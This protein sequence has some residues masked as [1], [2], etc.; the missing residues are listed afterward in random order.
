ME[1]VRYRVATTT[2]KNKGSSYETPTAVVT[3]R[4]APS[5]GDYDNYHPGRRQRSRRRDGY[6]APDD[7]VRVSTLSPP[8]S[9]IADAVRRRVDSSNVN[10][11]SE[12]F[13]AQPTY[14]AVDSRTSAR[15]R[16]RPRPPFA[17][18]FGVQRG[19]MSGDYDY[20]RES[21]DSSRYHEQ[22]LREESHH[23]QRHRQR[24]QQQ[25]AAS[26]NPSVEFA[27]RSIVDSRSQVHHNPT[28]LLP[29]RAVTSPTPAPL[30]P[31]YLNDNKTL[32][33]EALISAAAAK[34]A[35]SS[36]ARSAVK[37][38][39]VIRNGPAK[40]SSDER[41]DAD[42]DV[43]TT[44]AKSSVNSY[45]VE[46][47]ATTE[48][49]EHTAAD[50][51]IAAAAAAATR[52]SRTQRRDATNSGV[53]TTASS[54]VS[55]TG[56]GISTG[57]RRTR[58]V[59]CDTAAGDQASQGGVLSVSGTKKQDN[60]GFE[61]TRPVNSGGSPPASA[62]T[63]PSSNG[64]H[65]G[66]S[67]RPAAL[68]STTGTTHVT[69]TKETRGT[70]SDNRKD[71][72]PL[73]TDASRRD[74]QRDDKTIK[75]NDVTELDR[76]T[77]P[78]ADAGTHHESPSS[79]SKVSFIKSI[80]SR[81]RSP[82]P[83]RYRRSR[84]KPQHASG[85]PSSVK[86]IGA[87]VAQRI[88][89]PVKGYLKQLRDRS[90]QR[91]RQTE[92]GNTSTSGEPKSSVQDRELVSDMD[93]QLRPSDA[94]AGLAANCDGR[95][96]DDVSSQRHRFGTDKK[97]QDDG[98]TALTSQWKS[99]SE[100]IT[101]MNRLDNLLKAN[102]LQHLRPSTTASAFQTNGPSVETSGTRAVSSTSMTSSPPLVSQTS[103]S[104]GC[105][106]SS[107]DR[108]L[109]LHQEPVERQ[110][111]TTMSRCYLEK[112][113]RAARRAVTVQLDRRTVDRQTPALSVTGRQSTSQAD[114]RN[115]Q[116]S[117]VPSLGEQP[118]DKVKDSNVDKQLSDLTTSG[119]TATGPTSPASEQ[120][121]T[122]NRSSSSKNELDL[123]E[124]FEQKKLE[125]QL[126]EKLALMEKERAGVIA[127]L[128]SQI[129]HRCERKTATQQR[130]AA[131]SDHL[132]NSSTT[133]GL[134]LPLSHNTTSP[135][136]S[137]NQVKT[138]A[139]NQKDMHT[140]EIQSH[141]DFGT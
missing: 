6:A 52:R 72:Q 135:A 140:I 81:T 57:T 122:D 70:A 92:A 69:N 117:V 115:P 22:R 77:S 132:Y 111:A 99:T 87:E 47:S 64:D 91:R 136:A 9:A 4:Q 44:T 34:L 65:V 127:K 93:S 38:L 37:P 2:R 100:L 13:W 108:S 98:T 83:S 16:S 28:T 66:D 75:D 96:A 85:S 26:L 14:A 63:F 104:T 23:Q 134:V 43:T 128:W 41:I 24:Q 125:R 133:S 110:R 120:P 67:R 31:S 5:S 33:K 103:R 76:I 55:G 56:Q 19:D 11:R 106:L 36:S 20:V 116:P 105:L 137:N 46:S 25:H 30:S 3:S 53:T 89:M 78:V 40:S 32:L 7:V 101:P 141:A 54:V 90:T 74:I 1:N 138:R 86:R 29:G 118:V 60:V 15:S 10:S 139:V 48:L 95:S 80:L 71:V 130:T 94:S 68:L 131:V 119:K 17:L 61:R 45:G 102:S 39:V 123:R 58:A 129:D 112:P 73:T 109:T 18:E 42:D 88:G 126:E 35:R 113:P 107:A 97:K 49:T 27:T 114:L 84:S 79:T 12:S 62:Q 124:L 21:V 51:A 121:R 82:S 8:A 59:N 50:V